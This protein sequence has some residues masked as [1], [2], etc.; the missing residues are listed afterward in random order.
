M[1]ATAKPPSLT[2]PELKNSRHVEVLEKI[3]GQSMGWGDTEEF[4]GPEI[5]PSL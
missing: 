4:E 5:I 3:W 2:F 1:T